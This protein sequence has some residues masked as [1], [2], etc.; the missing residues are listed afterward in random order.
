MDGFDSAI[1]GTVQR[2]GQDE[3]IAYNYDKVIDINM[4]DGMSYEEAVEYF[5]FNQ[6]SAY[7][8][9]GTPCFIHEFTQQE[10]EL[11]L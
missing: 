8:G 2:I 10:R 11:L 5:E 6:A 7:M 9:E 4:N 1:I 3:I